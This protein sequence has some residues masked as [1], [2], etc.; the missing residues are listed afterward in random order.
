VK[1][2]QVRFSDSPDLNS[3]SH[4]AL[5]GTV[6]F[7]LRYFLRPLKN[8]EVGITAAGPSP[9]FLA[10][11]GITGFPFPGYHQYFSRL[12]TNSMR[13]CQEISEKIQKS[14]ITQISKKIPQ[15]FFFVKGSIIE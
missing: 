14:L 2:I 3:P 7:L 10:E 1:D 13:M 9:N 6:A 5:G 11:A 4:P 12:L 8:G 15:I